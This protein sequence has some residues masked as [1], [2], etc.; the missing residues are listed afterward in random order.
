MTSNQESVGGSV[1][2]TRWLTICIGWE[3][4]TAFPGAEFSGK[5]SSQGK[6]LTGG[7]LR[8]ANSPRLGP[9]VGVAWF[10]IA[11]QSL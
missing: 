3:C 6:N 9:E 4:P 11:P 5:M 7:L 1:P 2:I 10:G 8:S